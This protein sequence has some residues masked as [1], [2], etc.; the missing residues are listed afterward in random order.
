MIC[1]QFRCNVNFI[2]LPPVFHVRFFHRIHAWDEAN[3]DEK[4]RIHN[5]AWGNWAPAARRWGSDSSNNCEATTQRILEDI[6]VQ[7]TLHSSPV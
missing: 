5:N 1:I 6:Y 3:L 7:R 2:H 4:F